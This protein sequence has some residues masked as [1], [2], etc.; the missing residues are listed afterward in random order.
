MTGGGRLVTQWEREWKAGGGVTQSVRG[1]LG[2]IPRRPPGVW[3]ATDY[4]GGTE[5]VG[6]RLAGVML[7]QV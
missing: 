1:V 6:R 2:V 4:E 7:Q 5:K 3:V